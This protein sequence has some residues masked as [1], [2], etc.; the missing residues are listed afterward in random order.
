LGIALSTPTALLQ[1]GKLWPAVATATRQALARGALRPIETEQEEIEDGGIR[2]LVRCVSNLAHKAELRTPGQAANSADP[3]LPYDPMLFVAHVSRT[4]SILLNK[5]PVLEHHLLIVTRAFEHQETLL[6]AADFAALAACMAEFET[7]GFYNGGREAGASQ[8][9][10]HLQVVPLP[11][12][13]GQAEV[14]T[15]PLFRHAQLSGGG[16]VPG[17]PFRHA[18]ADLAGAIWERP[19]LTGELLTAIYRDLCRAAGIGEREAQGERR[20][21]APYNLLLTRE[22]M[23]LVPRS[24]EQY[25]SISVNALGFAGSLFVKDKA[26]LECVRDIGPMGLLQEVTVPP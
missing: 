13:S 3:F 25:A 18:Y 11:L 9:H 14:P 12:S 4:H 7:L 15:E 2:F 24:R 19:K 5:F 26:Q 21:S 10:K 20:Q 8:D 16:A 23:L 6:D 17:L 1:P 22:W